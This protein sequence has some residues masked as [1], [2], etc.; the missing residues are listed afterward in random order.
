MLHQH[1]SPCC[2]Y[3]QTG[4]RGNYVITAMHVLPFLPIAHLARYLQDETYPRLMG[5]LGAEPAITA[6]CMFADP[7]ADVAVLGPPDDQD[8]SDEHDLYEEFTARL[9]PFAV[10]PPPP[11]QLMRLDPFRDDPSSVYVAGDVSFPAYVLPLDGAW[12]A[13]T[14]RYLGGPLLI[15]PEDLVAGG[16]SGSLVI[17]ATGAA[18]GVVSTSNWAPCLTRS[19]PGRLLSALACS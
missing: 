17:S 7:I 8:L 10:A 5:A 11:R 14:A 12:I 1:L 19:L 16:M 13:C 2:W 3:E 4:A 6:S 9:A 18:L 15:E